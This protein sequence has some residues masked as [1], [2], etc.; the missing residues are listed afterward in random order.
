M[1]C[2]RPVPFLVRASA[3]FRPIRRGVGAKPTR[4]T[5]A[6][7]C[8][9]GVRADIGVHSTTAALLLFIYVRAARR[10]YRDLQEVC[11]DA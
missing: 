11:P 3:A 4:Q 9:A 2:L 7:R 10:E 8:P 5:Y 6:L 1:G